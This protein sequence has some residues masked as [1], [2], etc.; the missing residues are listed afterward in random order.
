MSQKRKQ[1]E[2]AYII[3][4]PEQQCPWQLSEALKSTVFKQMLSSIFAEEW[5]KAE[6]SGIIG[7]RHV[8]IYLAHQE[9][10]YCFTSVNGQVR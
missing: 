3:T 10:C 9:K 2:V 8:Y 1:R 7:K 6:Y 4:G 5:K